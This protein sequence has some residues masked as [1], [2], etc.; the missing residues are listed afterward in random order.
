VP[1]PP[2][3]AVPDKDVKELVEWILKMD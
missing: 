3:P 1:M 2:N